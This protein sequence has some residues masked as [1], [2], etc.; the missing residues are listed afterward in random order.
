MGAELG[1]Q[2]VSV[3]LKAVDCT[4]SV[5]KDVIAKMLEMHNEGTKHGQQSIKN[6]N[7]Q[8]KQL[9]NVEL[10]GEDVKSF[11]KELKRQGVDFCAMKDKESGN[12]IFY[13]KAQDVKRVY[14][15][16]EKVAKN[17]DKKPIKEAMEQAQQVA[18]EKNAEKA[19]ENKEK[20]NDVR[21]EER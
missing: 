18:Q 8:G 3:E 14:S 9:E 17:F 19:T 2:M 21:K 12:T 10:A 6:L 20:T 11:Q 13:F 16:L 1:E 15:G 4:L 7:R 5:L